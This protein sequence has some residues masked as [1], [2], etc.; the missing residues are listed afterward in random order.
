[1]KAETGAIRHEA[2]E[3]AVSTI[4]IYMARCCVGSPWFEFLRVLRVVRAEER[5]GA[6]R[7]EQRSELALR[8]PST[9][10]QDRLAK[11]TEQMESCRH[12]A[13]RAWRWA[14]PC[15]GSALLCPNFRKL[16][17]KATC[18]CSRTFGNSVQQSQSPGL[19]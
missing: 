15:Q 14:W 12:K 4:P 1:M 11:R 2:G 6:Q 10:A 3:N 19:Y 17:S 8:T 5:C 9:K 16:R 7:R 13:V 18:S